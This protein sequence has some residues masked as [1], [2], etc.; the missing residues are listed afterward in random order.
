MIIPRIQ[1]VQVPRFP[2]MPFVGGIV[3]V[4]VEACQVVWENGVRSTVVPKLSI[5]DDCIYTITLEDGR[6]GLRSSFFTVI[7]FHTGNVQRRTTVSSGF[8]C[9]TLCKGLAML[10]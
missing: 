6:F 4:D 3:F 2:K 9:K 10:V 1:K 8:F 7:D 5:A